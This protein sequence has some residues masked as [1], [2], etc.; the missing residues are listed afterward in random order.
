[1]DITVGPEEL[2]VPLG[3]GLVS[4]VPEEKRVAIIDGLD[5]RGA[6]PRPSNVIIPP[7][8]PKA[9]GQRFSTVMMRQPNGGILRLCWCQ[10]LPVPRIVKKQVMLVI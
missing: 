1:M 8:R 5:V 6:A 2:V 10:S 3:L 9:Q 7:T 4:L